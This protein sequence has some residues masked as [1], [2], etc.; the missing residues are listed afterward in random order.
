MA[1]PIAARNWKLN[2]DRSELTHIYKFNRP[3]SISVYRPSVKT[4]QKQKEKITLP[5][6][7]WSKPSVAKHD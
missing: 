7:R 1:R 3:R 2:K 5:D 6:L 4:I